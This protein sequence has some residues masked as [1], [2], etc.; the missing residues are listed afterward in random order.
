MNIKA[1]VFPTGSAAEADITYRNLVAMGLHPKWGKTVIYEDTI[2]LAVEEIPA[3]QALQ[4]V[5]P[6]V[7]GTVQP[8][9]LK[10]AKAKRG[11]DSLTD[12][13]KSS[14]GDRMAFQLGLK[15]AVP[16]GEKWEAPRYQLGPD[17]GT[18]TALGVFLIVMHLA[19]EAKQEAKK[20]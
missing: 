10:P 15:K 3:L 16:D 8:Y 6:T 1:Y 7:F 4:T 9:K 12:K 18:H 14:I 13:Q 17:Y 11:V 2:F 5:N 20:G 19:D